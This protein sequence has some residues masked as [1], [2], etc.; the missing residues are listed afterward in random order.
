MQNFQAFRIYTEGD[1]TR[2][3]IENLDLNEISTGEVLIETH[4]SSVNYKDAL[5]GTGKGKILRTSPLIGGIDVAGVVSASDDE[6]YKPG[7]QVLVTGC[8]LSEVHDGGYAEYVRVAAD[9]VIPLPGGL[10]LFQAMAI[11]TA[12]FTAALAIKRLEDNHQ[13]PEH[14]PI[15]VT[16]ATGGVGSFAI[17][18]LTG[19][20]Y[21]VVALSGKPDAH[22]YLESLGAKRILDRHEL[23]MGDQPLERPEWGGAVDNVGGDTLGWLTRTIKPWGN[24]VSIGLAGG[25]KLTTTVMPF[26]LRGVGLLGVSS[27]NCP[28]DWREPLWQRLSAD[29]KPRHLDEITSDTV[30]LEQL[31]DVFQRMLSGKTR[32]R[33][34][35][36]LKG[37]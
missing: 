9:W 33:V 12:G 36:S 15:L 29:L 28:L 6:R 20:G 14:G 27:S 1:T 31:P 16:G 5:A 21:E 37:K 3:G 18:M 23:K 11:G 10:D 19:L 7:D 8:G 17:D 4:Y 30:T 34:V 24:I 26:I 13:S 2:A 35:V 25:T 32:G 22:P